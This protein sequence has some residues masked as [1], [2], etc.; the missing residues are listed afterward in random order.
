MKEQYCH[1]ENVIFLKPEDKVDYSV[2][3]HV[4]NSELG[5]VV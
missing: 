5:D 1:L 3:F 2:S 4:K